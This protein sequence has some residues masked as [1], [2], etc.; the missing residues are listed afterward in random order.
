MK[1]FFIIGVIILTTVWIYHSKIQVIQP[2]VI[3]TNEDDSTFLD[4][5]R[6]A[7]HVIFRKAAL[8]TE[9][10]MVFGFRGTPDQNNSDNIADGYVAGI[11]ISTARTLLSLYPDLGQCG[12]PGNEQ[13]RQAI[14]D[15]Q[16]IAYTEHVNSAMQ[17]I[18]RYHNQ[19]LGNNDSRICVHLQGYQLEVVNATHNNNSVEMLTALNSL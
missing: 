7:L 18:E 19:A 16:V 13:A 6:G 14:Y 10:Y 11:P 15:I 8:I 9:T 4:V 17:N 12:H 2:N 5:R 3:I 1:K